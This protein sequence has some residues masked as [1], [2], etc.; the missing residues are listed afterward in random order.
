[1]FMSSPYFLR[2]G[3][4]LSVLRRLMAKL[5]AVKEFEI[6]QLVSRVLSTIVGYL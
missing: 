5:P 3:S 6:V 4:R 1:M 2:G